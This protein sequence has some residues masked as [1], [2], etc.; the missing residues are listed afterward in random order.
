MIVMWIFW[1]IVLVGFG[2]VLVTGIISTIIT[3]REAQFPSKFMI[4]LYG[5]LLF[6]TVYFCFT[7]IP[8]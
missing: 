4:I 6:V 3:N 8:K 5:F 7:H 2:S 1:F